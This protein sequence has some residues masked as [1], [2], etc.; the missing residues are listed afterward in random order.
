MSTESRDRRSPGARTRV[1]VGAVV[2]VVAGLSSRWLLVD[3]PLL[4]LAIIIVCSVVLVL[5]APKV[6]LLTIV[7]WVMVSAIV[8]QFP[9]LTIE[10][11]ALGT[12]AGLLT[13]LCLTGPMAVAAVLRHRREY[14]HRGWRLAAME[15]ERRSNDIQTALQR[16]RMSLAAEMHD[17]LGHSLT[18]IAVRLGQLSLTSTLAP[19]DRAAVTELRQA[20]AEA[21]EELGNAVRLLRDPGAIATGTGV[22]TIMDAVESARSAGIPVTTDVPEGLT[23]ILS[24]EA[25]T[26]VARLVQESLTNAAKHAPGEQVGIAIHVTGSTMVAE[27]SNAMPAQDGAD[28][29]PSSGFGLVG[30]RHR[31]GMLGGTLEV[32]RSPDVFALKLTLPTD[33]KP[34]PSDRVTAAEDIVAAE[35]EAAQSRTMATR[36]A[37][38]LPAAILGAV[39]AVTFAYLTAAT[40]LSVVSAPQFA[41]IQPG[42]PR[43][44]VEL[45]LPIFEVLDAPRD[46]FPPKSGEQCRY[47]ESDVSFFERSDVHVVC[48]DDDAVTRMGVIPAS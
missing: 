9:G 22:P 18:L 2:A 20:S 48:F 40:V 36:V 8:V 15:A 38:V 45:S 16:E 42:D 5:A 33:A 21:A 26:A 6:P 37:I 1:A 30:I 29:P 3:A 41:E 12:V 47:Y 39:L 34:S 19:A 10:N 46:Q 24:A 7:T 27:V 23:E 43:A 25:Q 4:A 35:N 28:R 17:G 44:E 11:L 32:G 13:S 14:L 31:A